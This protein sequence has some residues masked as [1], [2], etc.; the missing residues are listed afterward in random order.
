MSWPQRVGPNPEKN[1]PRRVRPRRVGGPKFRAIFPSPAT[2]FALFVSHCVSS[3]GFLV[4]FGSAGA[5]EC[6]QLRVPVFTKITKIQRED[7][8]CET[9]RAKLVV[10]DG[11]IARNF[12][13]RGGP[14]EG[15]P[16]EG[17]SG[18][19][20]VRRMVVQ[21]KNHTTN[22]NHNHNNKQQHTQHHTTTHNK[23]TAKH[24]PTPTTI[25]TN[26]NH[27]TTQH[28]KNG[29]AKHALAKIGLAKIGQTTNN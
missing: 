27:G 23:H 11:K 26:T 24:T 7:T 15:G 20:G 21:T 9:K 25:H 17:G 12:G 8:Q 10:G 2:S 3:R 1:R 28:N 4:V 22:T 14:V 13:R 5:V 18:G 19:E 6:A 16:P 29:L